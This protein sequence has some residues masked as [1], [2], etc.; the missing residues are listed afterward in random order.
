MWHNLT[1]IP[2][3]HQKGEKQ[4]RNYLGYLGLSFHILQKFQNPTPYSKKILAL[5]SATC[6]LLD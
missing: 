3:R 4:G 6:G 2:G 5:E 1:R